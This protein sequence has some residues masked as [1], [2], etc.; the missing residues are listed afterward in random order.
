VLVLI[1]E[2]SYRRKSSLCQKLECQRFKLCV[3][4]ET[5]LRAS[6]AGGKLLKV[7]VTCD[8]MSK[9]WLFDKPGKM[10]RQ[11]MKKFHLK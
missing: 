8:K 2:S 3:G 4:A 5:G 9:K 10:L 6:S 11:C 7:G 1:R